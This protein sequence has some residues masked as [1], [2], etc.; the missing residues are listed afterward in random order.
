MNSA[1]KRR[2]LASAILLLAV[3]V[4][5][6]AL[7]EVG[8]YVG[9]EGGWTHNVSTSMESTT[10]FTPNGLGQQ[11]STTSSRHKT[12]FHQGFIEGA[13]FGYALPGHLR[14][15]LEF[16][17][18]RNTVKGEDAAIS[19]YTMMGNVWYDFEQNNSYFYLGAGIG[20]AHVRL[21]DYAIDRH[22]TDDLFAYQFGV[23]AGFLINKCWAVG[24][25]YRYLNTVSDGRFV[26]GNY[27]AT[28]PSS[29]SSGTARTQVRSGFRGQSVMLGVRYNFGS[30]WDP[31][32]PYR[33][34][35]PVQVVPLDSGN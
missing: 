5:S 29:G 4:S 21:S 27:G 17:Y 32:N 13:T 16:D 2:V 9:I 14:P 8:P 33:E 11:P 15:E 7:A 18:R 12:M 6:S 28:D 1:C 30:L 10:T 25:D 34:E 3:G 23:G 35:R 31:L 19:A 22:D 24:V 26:F 20:D